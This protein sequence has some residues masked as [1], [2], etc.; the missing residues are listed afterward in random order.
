[1]AD[2]VIVVKD[3]VAKFVKAINDLAGLRVMIGVPADHPEGASPGSNQRNDG[4]TNALLA[5]IHNTGSPA[6]NIPARPHLV[7]G[8]EKALPRMVAFLRRAAT[9]ASKGNQQGMMQNLHAVGLLGQNAVRQE[10]TTGQFAPLAPATVRARMRKL[11]K[12]GGK[13]APGFTA[14]KPLLD[15][16]Q[17]R[18]AYAYVIRK[19]RVR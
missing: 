14:I 16:G 18:A 5:Y 13:V 9:F 4:P 15:S 8:V 11:A 17:L 10:I 1:M 12:S 3:D 19:V 2:P 7:P 6:Q